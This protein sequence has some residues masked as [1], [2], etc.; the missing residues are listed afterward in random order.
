MAA[1]ITSCLLRL[2]RAELRTRTGR[3]FRPVSSEKTNGTRTTSPDHNR[4]Y[5]ASRRLFQRSAS[6]GELAPTTARHTARDA[7][8]LG[9]LREKRNCS[10]R[11]T[12]SAL[13]VAIE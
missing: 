5:A 2:Y 7:F 12:S 4:S 11:G 1:T 10:E 6:T 13:D 3:I 9:G 8:T